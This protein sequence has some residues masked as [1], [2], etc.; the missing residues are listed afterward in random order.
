MVA[1]AGGLGA[2]LRLV[3]DGEVRAR[4]RSPF[5]WSTTVVNVSGSLLL[6]VVTGAV[7]FGEA[8]TTLQRL[9]GTGLCG[10]YTTFSTA[11][12]ET[13][14]LLR[15]GRFAL[16]AANAFGVTALSVAAAA[17]GLALAGAW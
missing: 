6:G 3:V 7:L 11:S 2:V 1:V 5:P 14:T 16:A 13:L 12:V 8:S 10:G 17:A 15:S 9:V 4:L